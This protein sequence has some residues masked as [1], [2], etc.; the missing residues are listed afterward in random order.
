MKP[1]PPPGSLLWR[2]LRLYQ[3][4]GAN[5]DVGKTVFATLLAG[6]AKSRWPDEA[7]TYLK[8][9]S[10][11]PAHEADDRHIQRFAAGVARQ[12][13]FQYELPVSPHAAA[14]ASDKASLGRRRGKRLAFL[15]VAT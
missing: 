15:T 8:P 13:L 3:L 9:V 5:T 11:G 7:V 1:P 14:R 10:T 4:F 2:S 6:S 12:T